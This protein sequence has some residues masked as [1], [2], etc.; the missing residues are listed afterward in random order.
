MLHWNWRHLGSSLMVY[1][2]VYSLTYI[3]KATVQ[4]F[5]CITLWSSLIRVMKR[6]SLVVLRTNHRLDPDSREKGVPCTS[7]S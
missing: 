1:I 2:R 6:F 3:H 7:R 5:A 4:C